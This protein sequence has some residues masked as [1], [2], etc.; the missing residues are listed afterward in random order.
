MLKTT[1]MQET[2]KCPQYNTSLQLCSFLAYVISYIIITV[3]S[4]QWFQI[5]Y[6]FIFKLH[7]NN[8][9]NF[10]NKNVDIKYIECM[11]LIGL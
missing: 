6:I 10:I 2:L 7:L 9:V 4:N 3:Y 11:I 1:N 5:Y 8:Q